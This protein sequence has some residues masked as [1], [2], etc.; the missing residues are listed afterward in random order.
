MAAHMAHQAMEAALV[1]RATHE[2]AI[3]AGVAAHAT[4]L[5]GGETTHM[6]D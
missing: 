3:A 1:A 2:E 4:T 6:L 5:G